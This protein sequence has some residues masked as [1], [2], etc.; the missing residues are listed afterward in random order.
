MQLTGD[1]RN[2]FIKYQH[3]LTQRVTLI[4]WLTRCHVD[5]YD[6]LYVEAGVITSFGREDDITGV[7]IGDH[8]YLE[9]DNIQAGGIY[10]LAERG[11]EKVSD[12][13]VAVESVDTA[14][15]RFTFF[16]LNKAIEA[17]F[18]V[19]DTF[20]LEPGDIANYTG[21]NL[22]PIETTVGIF[23]LN[24]I[25]FA[26]VFGSTIP[27]VNDL[28]VP[29]KIEGMV[30]NALI[31]KKITV[32]QHYKF[33][34]HMYFIGHFTELSVPTFTR[35][36]FTTDKRVRMR[37]KELFAEHE[38][39]LS[40]P[41]VAKKIEDDLMALDRE[42]IINDPSA[43]FYIPLGEK[44]TLG[45]HRKKMFLTVGGI[46]SFDEGTG[47]YDF[48]RN[49]LRDGW[50][51]RDFI[52]ICNEIRKGSY[53]RGKETEKGGTLTKF[54]SRVFQNLEIV[55]DDCR[56]RRGLV[57]TLEADIANNYL[58][59]T[60]ID[61]DRDVVLTPE[62]IASYIDKTIKLRSPMYCES[63]TGLCYACTSQRM[64]TLGVRRV[65]MQIVDVSSTFT[66][67]SMKNMHGTKIELAKINFKKYFT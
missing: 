1:R 30:A 49:S 43:R 45:I 26:S 60:I 38:G 63:K 33:L 3:Q 50:D 10:I 19:Y 41:I 4:E 8:A 46:E 22:K 40:D 20:I 9:G 59:R 29:N 12:I 58:S 48:I 39:H 66:T 24:Y 64:Q 53:F 17:P 34:D 47:G 18:R 15:K 42:H 62:N 55:E 35:K 61:N 28:W 25:V 16:R 52:T 7:K 54:L 51:K 27:Y 44:N 56:T 6:R 13:L 32:P 21:D 57:F 36:S 67:L 37:A 14:N 31:T 65:S 5:S 23:I 2:Y 11:S